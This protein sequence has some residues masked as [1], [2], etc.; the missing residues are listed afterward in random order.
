[1]PTFHCA[2]G[3]FQLDRFP[4]RRNEQL[5]PFDAADALILKHLASLK[6]ITKEN[7][8]GK[9]ILVIND[10]FGALS[11]ALTYAGY[12]V[13]AWNDSVT[14]HQAISHNCR[15]HQ[16]RPPRLT[17]S[18]E[19]PVNAPQIVILRPPKSLAMLELQLAVLRQQLR[20]QP[21]VI[22]G[23]MAKYIKRSEIDL[24]ERSIGPTVTSHAEKKARLILPTWDMTLNP[25]SPPSPNTFSVPELELTLHNH[26]NVFARKRLDIGARFMLSQFTQ[27]PDAQH[28]IDLGCGNGVLG[29][30]AKRQQPNATIQFVDESYMAIES[31]KENYQKNGGDVANVEFIVNDCLDG[32]APQSTDLI[33]C[34][35]PFHQD[36]VQNTAI[37]HTMFRQSKAALKNAGQLW[38]VANRHLPYY[39]MLKTLF[40]AVKTLGAH[41]KF[42]VYQ[43]M[44]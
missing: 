6:N 5:Q 30:M 8:G 24:I 35:P 36:N 44:Q 34:N 2:F 41:R 14:Q 17:P 38:V 31:A 33:L 4:L 22:A 43:C 11:T 12:P 27:L 15:S 42:T 16:L 39:P 23:A 28:I 3:E 19:P 40:R 29:I 1:M 20:T 37:A 9:N 7:T 32:V 18:T 13:E 25:P 26:A 21:I 10:H